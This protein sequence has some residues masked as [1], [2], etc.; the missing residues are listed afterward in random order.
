MSSRSKRRVIAQE[1]IDIMERGHYTTEDGHKVSIRTTQ[2]KA[3]EGSF[4]VHPD[5]W[6]SVLSE[7]QSR[8]KH[9]ENAPEA[10]LEV[11]AE[12]TFAAC[13]RLI[14]EES[15]TSVMALNFASA[16]NPGG[17][18]LNGSQAQEEALTRASGLYNCLLAN[19]DYYG[20]N[21]SFG[22]TLYS[23]Y[24]IFALE[25]PVFRDDND[26]LLP[27]SYA[28]SILT[29][30]AVNAGALRKNSPKH[31]PKIGPTMRRRTEY[32]LALALREGMETLVLGAWGCGVFRND[33]TEIAEHFAHF[34]EPGGT[35]AKAFRR[36]VFAIPDFKGSGQNLDAFREVFGKG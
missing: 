36:V 15:E 16:K 10:R 17:G 8:L 13:R 1:T 5:H 31:I 2:K 11:V 33:P 12:T 32:V 4:S 29:A 21:R 19:G 30:P 20:F 34:L 27:E 9:A 24:M 23:D 26:T 25:V 18:F 7:A 6:D 14:T 22:S 28:V 35:Y 3:V